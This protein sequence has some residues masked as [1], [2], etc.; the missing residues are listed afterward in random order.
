M[1]NSALGVAASPWICE[2]PPNAN[3]VILRT[4]RPYTRAVSECD[5]SWMT[6]DAAMAIPNAIARMMRPASTPVE[7]NLGSPNPWYAA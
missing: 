1:A 4:G 7:P 6:I 2:T 5:S 3:S